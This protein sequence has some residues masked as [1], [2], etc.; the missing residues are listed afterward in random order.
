[1]T[2]T[3]PNLQRSPG[4]LPRIAAAE[5]ESDAAHARCRCLPPQGWGILW[6]VISVLLMGAGILAGIAAF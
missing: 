5:S 6:A 1:M 4:I 3:Q 2:V